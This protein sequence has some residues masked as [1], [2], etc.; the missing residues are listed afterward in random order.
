MGRKKQKV[1]W[2]SVEEEFFGNNETTTAET[3]IT[4]NSAGQQNGNTETNANNPPD[5][6]MSVQP[7]KMV[8]TAEIIVTKS[9]TGGYNVKV[10]NSQTAA[11]TSVPA[12]TSQTSNHHSHYNNRDKQRHNSDSSSVSNHHNGHGGGSNGHHGGQGKTIV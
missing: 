8:P 11:V 5:P 3:M 6:D 7:V 10:A 1:K 2:T 9:P 12:E 4:E